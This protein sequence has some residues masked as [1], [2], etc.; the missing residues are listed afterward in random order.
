LDE[1]NRSFGLFFDPSRIKPRRRM[2]GPQATPV[3]VEPIPV[4]GR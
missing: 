4:C 3:G 1:L 2:C